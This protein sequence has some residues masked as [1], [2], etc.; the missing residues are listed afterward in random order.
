MLGKSTEQT[1][2]FGMRS[3]RYILLFLLNI[4][5]ISCEVG[6]VRKQSPI[7]GSSSVLPNIVLIIADDMAWN[8]C[9][10]YGHPHIQTPNL[11]RLAKQ[12]MR[13]DQAFLTTSSCSPSRSSII[14]G[15]YPHQTDAEQLHWPLPGYNTTFVELLKSSGY[16]TAQSGKWHL[17]E[18]VK[19]R[20]DLVRAGGSEEDRARTPRDG[21]GAEDWVQTLREAP[22]DQP[23]FLWLAAFDPHRAYKQGVI[24]RTHAIEEVI[25]P[26]YLPDTREVRQ[27]LALYYDEISRLDTYV[28]KLWEE[29][30]EQGK[31]NNTCILFISDNGRPFPRDKTTLYDG[32]IRTPFIAYWP[33][34]IKEGSTSDA[35]VS[36]IDIAPTCL[37]LAGAEIPSSME[38][39]SL[40]PLLKDP[41]STE[42]LR[43]FVVAEDHW[44]DHDDF[45][46]AIRTEQFKYIR[47]FYPELP[48][49][50]PA[51]ALKGM[52]YLSMLALKETGELTSAQS[53]IFLPQRN[54][55][56]LYDINLDPEELNNLVE[57]E[58]YQ[59]VLDGMRARLSTW[60]EHSG[61]RLPEKRTPDEYDRVTGDPL[62][63]RSMKRVSN[64]KVND[65]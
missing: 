48:N 9:G 14:T 42:T 60:Q 37:A 6:C 19:D 58:S 40:V 21:S 29:L 47:N 13:F 65:T 11:N 52:A 4:S 38:G 45:G 39:I 59:E 17:G 5:I 24:P 31:E 41:S 62:P 7:Q 43:S 33:D 36:S 3:T 28:G 53:R 16:W 54:P 30:K 61:D 2:N 27:D 10:A 32:G 25:V 57:D 35:L 23:F 34:Q 64:K 8:D 56:E 49:T 55:E 20:F 22:A 63:N 50:P 51:D 15:K 26:S 1:R 12:G 44:H 46:R 18:E